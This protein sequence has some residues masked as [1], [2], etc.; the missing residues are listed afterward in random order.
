MLCCSQISLS[1]DIVCGV[2]EATLFLIFTKG[3]CTCTMSFFHNL[4]VYLPTSQTLKSNPHHRGNLVCL[5]K[6]TPK[7]KSAPCNKNRK[8]TSDHY[9]DFLTMTQWQYSFV[10][11]STN[12][13]LTTKIAGVA[14]ISNRLNTQHRFHCPSWVGEKNRVYKK[15]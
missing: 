10:L 1:F 7:K 11:F 2:S 12:A 4:Q 13:W 15:N 14:I 5:V 6:F 3:Y 8:K 9:C